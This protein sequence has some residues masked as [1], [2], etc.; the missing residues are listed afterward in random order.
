MLRVD[1]HVSMADAVAIASVI[2]SATVAIAVP[3]V[4]AHFQ[5]RERV[6]VREQAAFDELRQ[7]LASLAALP[8][9]GIERH[10]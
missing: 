10:S 2:S 9:L 4:A 6:L 5:R 3:V 7:T 8:K 1:P